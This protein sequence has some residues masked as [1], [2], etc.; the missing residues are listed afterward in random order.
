MIIKFSKINTL[1]NYI[2]LFRLLLIVPVLFFMV[3]NYRNNFILF[4]LCIVAY[5]S[6]VLDGYIARKFNQIS[7]FGK[8]IDPLADKILMGGLVLLMYSYGDI[9]H[10]YFISVVLRDVLI[11]LGGIFITNKLGY[12]LPSNL[13]GKATVFLIGIF[14]LAKMI[15]GNSDSS[16][17]NI[18]E[19][20]SFIFILISFGSYFYR[21]VEVYT[22][23]KKYYGISEKF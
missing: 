11:F 21:A 10:Y 2:S 22:W 19:I 23:K 7:E 3:Y 14:L 6:D 17:I 16:I 4:S 1:S 9:P 18:F 5:I 8:I 13:I 15:M 12:V 20:I